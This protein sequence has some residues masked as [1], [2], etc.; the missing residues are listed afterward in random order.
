MTS[1]DVRL[2][3]TSIRGWVTSCRSE[4]ANTS[5]VSHAQT[6]AL[7][8]GVTLVGADREL[9][10]DGYY[11]RVLGL[12]TDGCYPCPERLR[13]LRNERARAWRLWISAKRMDVGW[14]G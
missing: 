8:R 14:C 13:S 3:L 10:C 5:V 2:E 11:P 4:A 6:A 1:A 7:G 12:G 9:R